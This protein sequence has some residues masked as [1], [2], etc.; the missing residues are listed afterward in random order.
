M[1][2]RWGLEELPGLL[3]ELGSERP[4]LVA[5]P[6]WEPPVEVVCA[7]VG[8]SLGPHRGGGAGDRRRG[9]ISRRRGR[10]RDRPREGDLGRDRPPGRLGPDDVLGRRVDAELRRARPRPEA[11]RRRLRGRPGRDRLRPRADGRPAESGDGR[12]LHERPRARRGGAVRGGPES[13]GRPR[14]ARR[15]GAHLRL[16][17]ACRREPGR[18]RGTPAPARRSDA[19]RRGARVSGARAR[20]RAG[21][22][23]RRALRAPARSDERALASAGASLQRARR[24][25]IDRSASARRWARTIRSGASRSW[26]GSATSA[27]CATSACRRTSWQRLRKQQGS[28]RAPARTR[29]RRPSPHSS[30]FYALSGSEAFQALP[31]SYSRLPPHITSLDEQ[32]SSRSDGLTPAGGCSFPRAARNASTTS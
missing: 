29:A 22:D 8:G 13:R 27:A 16:A 7:L 4:F 17:A 3:A 14:S 1:K 15:R 30:N 9:S 31:T 5:S 26:P 21:A 20:S 18:P 11:A 6:R 25:R 12:H 23:A 32:A 2:V 28:G 10:E 24:R 19:R